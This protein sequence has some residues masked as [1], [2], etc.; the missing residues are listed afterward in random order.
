[1]IVFTETTDEGCQSGESRHVVLMSRKECQVLVEA[2][3]AAIKA[4][5]KKQ[6]FKKLQKEL[7]DQL[8]VF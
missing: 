8:I 6:S 2:V 4:N 1:M 7:T 5:P 3:D